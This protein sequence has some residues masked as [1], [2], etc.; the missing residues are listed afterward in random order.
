[1]E[2]FGKHASAETNSRNNRRAAFFVRFMPRAYKKDKEDPLSQSS[3]GDPSEQLVEV[4]EDG[5]K[6]SGVEC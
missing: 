1:M 5:D 3:S 4:R 2:R 6:S